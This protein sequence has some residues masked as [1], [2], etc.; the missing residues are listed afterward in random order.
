MIRDPPF[1]H[2]ELVNEHPSQFFVNF[3]TISHYFFRQLFT[4]RERE[5]EFADLF[6][7][8]FDAD[9]SDCQLCGPR[10]VPGSESVAFI[11]K[12]KRDVVGEVAC[13][14]SCA[15][16]ATPSQPQHT[17]HVRVTA[18]RTGLEHRDYVG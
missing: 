1:K 3:F 10:S 13:C 15:L 17:H 11:N 18:S 2:G 14:G 5:R 16:S 7:E 8:S 12:R 9:G 6:A 4:A